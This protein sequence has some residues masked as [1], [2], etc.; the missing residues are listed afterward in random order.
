MLIRDQLR[1]QG[2]TLFRWRSVLP[3]LLLPLGL[4]ALP[5]SA[6]IEQRYGRTA[7]DAFEALC[8]AVS[9]LGL[10]LRIAVAGYVPRRTSGRQT[11]K[12][13]VASSLNTTG[14]YSLLRHPL[15]LA[16][17][18]IFAGFLLTTASLWPLLVGGLCFWIYYE[19]IAFAEEEF[20]LREFGESYAAW[21]RATPALLPRLSAWRRPALPFSWRHAVRREYRTVCA[22]LL[23]FAV[24]DVLE[25]AL[26][27]GRFALEPRAR[28]LLAAAAL[29]FVSIRLVDKR[30]RLLRVTD[31]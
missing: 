30:T 13:M 19:R 6:W 15:Y 26:A 3:L 9:A 17:F 2:E 27:H 11:R 14:L 20:L 24:L 22:T 4:L 23:A 29:L 31:R 25:D 8:M 16:N 28:W 12:G 1:R 7:D 18:A 10:A 5:G 21:A